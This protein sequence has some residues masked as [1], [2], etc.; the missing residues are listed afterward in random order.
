MREELQKG[1]RS[2]LSDR[3]HELMEDRLKKKEQIMKKRN[4]TKNKPLSPEE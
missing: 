4:P 2:I 1:N 3:L